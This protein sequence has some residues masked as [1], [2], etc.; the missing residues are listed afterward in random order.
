VILPIIL[1]VMV[2]ITE[3]WFL[4]DLVTYML[5]LVGLYAIP[6]GLAR[7]VSS[8]KNKCFLTPELAPT[9]AARDEDLLALLGIMTRVLDGYGYE[10][11]TGAQGHRGYRER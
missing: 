8:I 6:K 7:L 11:D 3:T 5:W 9:F 10:S 1:L 2:L 4:A